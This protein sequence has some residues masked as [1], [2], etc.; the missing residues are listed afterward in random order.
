ML[1]TVDFDGSRNRHATL[2]WYMNVPKAGGETCFPRA[3]G[4]ALGCG[5]QIPAAPE[6]RFWH[7]RHCHRAWGLQCVR[8]FGR[9]LCNF[10]FGRLH[11]R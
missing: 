3:G 6:S 9:L 10:G 7:E 2:L 4:R 1:A 11:F 5:L 8:V